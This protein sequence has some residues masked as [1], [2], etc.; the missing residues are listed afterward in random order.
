MAVHTLLC[1]EPD[2]AALATIRGALEPHGFQVTNI[3]NGEEAV[4]WGRQNQ[5]KLVIVSVEP[6]K[7]GYAICNKFKR[8]PELKDIPLLLTSGEETP[9]QLEQH[10][11]LKVKANE[12][13]VK[14]F[15]AQQLLDKVSEVYPLNGTDEKGLNRSASRQRGAEGAED[16]DVLLSSDVLEEIS[17]GDSDIVE[18][19]SQEL[20]VEAADF[21]NES[22]HAVNPQSL[23]D[24]FDSE[25]DAAFAAIQQQPSSGGAAAPSALAS[26]WES[27]SNRWDLDATAAVDIGEDEV[28]DALAKL[29]DATSRE[30]DSASSMRL[31]TRAVSSS[32]V[33]L[34]SV[35]VLITANI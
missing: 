19:D 18:D 32:P 11:K 4:A 31:P 26:P 1:V 17:I 7:I 22:T 21:G 24:V 2:A 23:D 5:P 33:I 35:S 15:S 8:N 10:R 34:P 28:D 13:L 6:R 27:V 3:T 29:T 14:P 20:I 25:T 9:Q 30:A 12:Y 16:D